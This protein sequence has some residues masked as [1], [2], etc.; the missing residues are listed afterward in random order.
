[1]IPPIVVKPLTIPDIREILG[2]PNQNAAD[3]ARRACDF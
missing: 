1:M 3:A 2:G